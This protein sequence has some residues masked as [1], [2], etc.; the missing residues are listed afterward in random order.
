ML[1]QKC[2]KELPEN[3]VFCPYCG[4]KQ[5]SQ[6][7]KTRKRPNGTGNIS[8]LSGS[9]RKPWVV[10]KNGQLIGTYE[11]RTDAVK[12]LERLTDATITEKYNWTFKQ[13]YEAW[14]PEHALEVGESG[15]KSMRSAYNACPELHD[16]KFRDLHRS[17]FQAVLSD[18][19]MEDKSKSTCEKMLQLFN[20][21]SDWAVAEEILQV[22]RSRTCKIVAEQKSEGRVIP[23]EFIKKIQT[24]K[25]KAAK[26]A[27][28]ILSC[29]CRPADLFRAKVEDCTEYYFISGSKTKAGKGRTIVVS[30]IGLDAYHS[31][32]EKARSSGKPKL[33]DGYSGNKEYR[34]FCRRDFSML[35]E[36]IGLEGYSPYD[37]RHTYVTYSKLAKVDPSILARSVGHADPSTT[38][39]FYVH[40]QSQEI[41]DALSQYNIYPGL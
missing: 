40:L 19:V 14:K 30:P 21:L 16:R 1:C 37:C 7:R 17:D 8:K 4:K 9:R 27:L 15:Q 41:Y 11:T 33:I 26:I 25:S 38:D 22:S 32:L 20:A 2:K 39:K 34:N 10:R 24:A 23:V 36:E 31:L 3:A 6:P 18:M 29:G 35:M 28:I 5:L 12:A 13:I